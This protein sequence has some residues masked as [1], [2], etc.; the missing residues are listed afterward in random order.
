MSTSTEQKVNREKVVAKAYR[1]E[2]RTERMLE[3]GNVVVEDQ[4]RTVV[5]ESYAKAVQILLEDHSM[6]NPAERR[7]SAF[8]VAVKGPE[9]EDV[10]IV[11]SLFKKRQDD[12]ADYYLNPAKHGSVWIEVGN[13]AIHLNRTMKGV[14]IT[15][16]P[17]GCE[18]S[19]PL[20]DQAITYRDAFEAR[21]EDEVVND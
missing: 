2:Y 16:Y 19:E 13:I 7:H 14:F 1:L 5:A 9:N 15:A 20:L 10:D 12:D 3:D 21:A 11:P 4:T 8:I 18:M 17:S 6:T